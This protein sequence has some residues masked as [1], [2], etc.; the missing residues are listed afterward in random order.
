MTLYLD[1][2]DDTSRCSSIHTISY[3]TL[4][5][6]SR[7]YLR[8]GSLSGVLLPTSHETVV[9]FQLYGICVLVTAPSKYEVRLDM[10]SG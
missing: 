6:H 2:M 7:D 8:L 4:W 9:Y 5:E 3:R 10:L 1:H